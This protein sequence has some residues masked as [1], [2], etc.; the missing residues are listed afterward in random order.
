MCED[1]DQLAAPRDGYPPSHGFAADLHYRETQTADL[2]Q[3]RDIDLRGLLEALNAAQEIETVCRVYARMVLGHEDDE[4]NESILAGLRD[5]GFD[6]PA[7]G[8]CH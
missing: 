7:P 6:V 2:I 3:K 4:S 8:T 1:I 5:A